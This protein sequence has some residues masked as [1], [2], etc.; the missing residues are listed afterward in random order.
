MKLLP[1]CAVD[2]GFNTPPCGDPLSRQAGLRPLG[3]HYASVLAM[4]SPRKVC[5]APIRAVEAGGGTGYFPGSGCG[6]CF[7]KAQCANSRASGCVRP[8]GRKCLNIRIPE[9]E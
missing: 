7:T 1:C 8:G 5:R 3:A 4:W 6:S 9:Y 2:A